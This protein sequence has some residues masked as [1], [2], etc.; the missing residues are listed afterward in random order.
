MGQAEALRMYI[1]PSEDLRSVIEALAKEL[2]LQE[3]SG[4]PAILLGDQNSANISVRA[5]N[6]GEIEYIINDSLIT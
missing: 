2:R 6:D 5:R 1:P 3:D 4:S